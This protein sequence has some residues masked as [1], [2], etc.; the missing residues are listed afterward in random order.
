MLKPLKREEL[1]G[2]PSTACFYFSRAPLICETCSTVGLRGGEALGPNRKQKT[3]SGRAVNLLK[4][5]CTVLQKE[6][7]ISICSSVR[8]HSDEKAI[9][10][11]RRT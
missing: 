7:E 4:S 1:E 8:F 11:S 9:Q 5:E 3:R 10:N 6:N 2:K